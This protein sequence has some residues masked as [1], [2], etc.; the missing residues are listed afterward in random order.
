MIPSSRRQ[1]REFRE[2]WMEAVSLSNREMPR[3]GPAQGQE[4]RGPGGRLGSGDGT[5]L[6]SSEQPRVEETL[7]DHLVQPFMGKR[8]CR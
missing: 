3:K 1:G 4:V 8:E 7:K 5:S 2:G 6:R